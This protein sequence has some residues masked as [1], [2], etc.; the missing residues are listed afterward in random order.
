MAMIDGRRDS[1][2]FWFNN[3][4]SYILIFISSLKKEFL[5]KEQIIIINIAEINRYEINRHC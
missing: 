2:T 5:S 4:C 3:F 1:L